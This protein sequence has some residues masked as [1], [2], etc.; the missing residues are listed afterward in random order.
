MRGVSALFLDPFYLIVD[1]A[2]W[3]PRLLPQGVRLVQLRVK[4]RDEAAL[5]EEILRARDL[6]AAHGAQLVVNDHWRLAIDLACDFVHLG[7]GDLDT[8]D[9]AA[10]RAHGLRLGVSTH[11]EAELERAL[12]LAPDY[13]ALGPIYPT[14]LKQMAVGPQGLDKLGLWKRRIGALPLVAIGGLTPERAR[15]ALAAGADSACVV[16]DVLRAADPQART[17]EWVEA[18]RGE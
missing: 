15:A 17:R 12:S 7:Q 11:D 5:R 3:L 14:L 18:T 16:T 6:C 8:A 1:A 13:V 10:I 9:I 4:G 2:D